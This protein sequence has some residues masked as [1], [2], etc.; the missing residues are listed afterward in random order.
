[1][2]SLKRGYWLAYDDSLWLLAISGRVRITIVAY[3]SSMWLT[4]IS[5]EVEDNVISVKGG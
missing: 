3:L 1:M 5:F 2:G 4:E